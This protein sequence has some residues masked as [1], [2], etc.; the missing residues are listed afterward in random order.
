MHRRCHRETHHL[1]E[2]LTRL[3][4]KY[5]PI[6]AHLLTRLPHLS[7]LESL[8]DV[9]AA[10]T[11]LRGVGQLHPTTILAA[12]ASSSPAPP[13]ASSPVALVASASTRGLHYT[14]CDCDSHMF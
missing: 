1:Y 4:S 3:Q 5:E 11:L 12:W 10:D 13:V 9:R 6:R 7:V 14:Y 8:T 2:F